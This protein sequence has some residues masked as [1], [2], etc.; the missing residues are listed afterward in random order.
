MDVAKGGRPNAE[1]GGRDIDNDDDDLGDPQVDDGSTGEDRR[2]RFR[3]GSDGTGWAAW[4][5]T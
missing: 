4:R 2:A 5:F 1:I 3:G